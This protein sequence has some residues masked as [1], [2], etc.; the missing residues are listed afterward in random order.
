[1]GKTTKNN[2]IK[3]INNG[4]KIIDLKINEMKK[5]WTTGFIEALK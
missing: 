3:I 2:S 1:M 4:K 5:A